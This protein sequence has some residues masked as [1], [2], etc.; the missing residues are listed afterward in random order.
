[1][2]TLP[3]VQTQTFYVDFID[4]PFKVEFLCDA[5]GV[6]AF[7]YPDVTIYSID[8]KPETVYSD[9]V[10]EKINEAILFHCFKDVKSEREFQ[11]EAK[12]DEIY[13]GN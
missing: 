1:M 12:G 2:A 4:S 13:R 6:S 10:R 7:E 8:G 3:K 11:E 5:K 9:E